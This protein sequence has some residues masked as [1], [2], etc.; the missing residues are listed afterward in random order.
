MAKTSN[1][2]E[3]SSREAVFPLEGEIDLHRSPSVSA[4]LQEI[5]ARKPN[6]LLIDLSRVSY[7]D[8]SAI[9]VFMEAMQKVEKYGGTFGL[10]GLQE[11]VRTI[12]EFAQLHQVF[13]IFPD[14]AAASAA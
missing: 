12:F 9:A 13:K 6:R 3:R 11:S 1:V 14:L 10:I 4:S 5:I 7:V 8:S 2:T